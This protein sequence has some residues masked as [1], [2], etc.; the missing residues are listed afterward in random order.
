MSQ[1]NLIIPEGLWTE[2]NFP[3]PYIKTQ[4]N[5]LHN[6]I[7][8]YGFIRKIEY[9]PEGLPKDTVMKIQDEEGHDYYFRGPEAY[10]AIVREYHWVNIYHAVHFFANEETKAVL[11]IL[12]E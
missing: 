6:M 11:S 2:A 1:N 10:D 12:M 5:K 4:L 8:K 7:F 9:G 3:F